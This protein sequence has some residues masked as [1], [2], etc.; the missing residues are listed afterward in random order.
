MIFNKTAGT[1]GRFAIKEGAYL[2]LPANAGDIC[3]DTI[4]R[5]CERK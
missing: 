2:C 4:V 5:T 1:P 3:A